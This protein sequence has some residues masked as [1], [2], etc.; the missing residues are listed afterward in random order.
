MSGR[1][2]EEK[3][4]ESVAAENASVLITSFL[5]EEETIAFHVK[6]GIPVPDQRVVPGMIFRTQLIMSM[7]KDGGD[8]LGE[9]RYVKVSQSDADILLFSMGAMRVFIVVAARPYNEDKLV[10]SIMRKLQDGLMIP[11]N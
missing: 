6:K 11:S 10:G 3:L 4:C 8:Y 1:I 5:Q 2:M 9:L 7:I